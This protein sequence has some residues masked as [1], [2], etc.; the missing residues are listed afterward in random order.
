MRIN[1]IE[2]IN[3]LF[4]FEHEKYGTFVRAKIHLKEG[5]IYL[6]I[7]NYCT[8]LRKNLIEFDLFSVVTTLVI[9][10]SSNG[11]CSSAV[12]CTFTQKQKETSE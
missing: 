6:Y 2:L 9:L 1:E 10:I 12:L 11:R 5:F 7:S 8:Y 3:I 4:A